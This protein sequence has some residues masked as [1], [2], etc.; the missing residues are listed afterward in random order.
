MVEKTWPAPGPKVVTSSNMRAFSILLIILSLVMAACESEATPATAVSSKESPTGQVTSSWSVSKTPTPLQSPPTITSNPTPTVLGSLLAYE[1]TPTATTILPDAA[2]PTSIASPTITS[3]RIGPLRVQEPSLAAINDY[4]LSINSEEFPFASPLT[5][6]ATLLYEDVNGDAVNDLIISDYLRVVILLWLG[7]AYSDPYLLERLPPWKYAPASRIQL[8]DWTN[9]SV[10]EVIFDHNADTGGTGILHDAWYRYIIHCSSNNCNVVWVG[11]LAAITSDFNSGGIDIYTADLRLDTQTSKPRLR[12]VSEYFSIYSNGFYLPDNGLAALNY[13][14]QNLTV[15][16]STLSIYE[17]NDQSFELKDEQIIHLPQSTPDDSKLEAT[18]NNGNLA[19]IHVTAVAAV[20][21]QNDRC[22]LIL[23]GEMVGEVFGCK[24]NFTS[25]EWKD[26][27]G[28]GQDEIVVIALSGT[29]DP[30]Q[31]IDI[32]AS[33]VHQRLLAYQWDG[34]TISEIANIYGCVVRPNLFG[35]KIEDFDS[36]GE[37][38]VIAARWYSD[39]DPDCE[40]IQS[41]SAGFQ[42]PCYH[43]LQ[44]NQ[45]IYKWNGSQFVFWDSV[46]GRI[47]S[48]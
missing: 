8:L 17:W 46:F 40:T 9:D 37:L 20:T 38:E 10:P 26:I 19:K 34:T 36:D 35:V 25:V 22:E 2:S 12:Y 42:I 15:F 45:W 7:D 48:D 41:E 24:H 39:P 14:L 5:E 21:N 23:D 6:I 27:T 43:D 29:S 28:D 44:Y 11:T 4:L 31:A 3:G 16:T 18:G 30:E 32:D 1:L 13:D 33:C 47:L